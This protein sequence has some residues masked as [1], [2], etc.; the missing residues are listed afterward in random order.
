MKKILTLSLYGLFL[1]SSI[2]AISQPVT[3]KIG[4]YYT[5]ATNKAST[6][7]TISDADDRITKVQDVLDDISPGSY[8]AVLTS[9]TQIDY[10]EP[11]HRSGGDYT[12]GKFNGMRQIFAELIDQVAA[13]SYYDDLSGTESLGNLQSNEVD[14]DYAKLDLAVRSD[15]NIFIVDEEGTDDYYFVDNPLTEDRLGTEYTG[16]AYEGILPTVIKVDEYKTNIRSIALAVFGLLADPDNATVI[17]EESTSGS[18]LSFFSYYY[19]P[20][21]TSFILNTSLSSDNKCVFKQSLQKMKMD[22][23]DIIDVNGDVKGNNKRVKIDAGNYVRI[24]SASSTPVVLAPTGSADFVAITT[25]AYTTDSNKNPTC[26]INSN[27][28]TATASLADENESF[29]TKQPDEIISSPLTLYPNPFTNTF[30]VV[31]EQVEN[32]SGVVVARVYDLSGR[33]VLEQQYSVGNS[34]SVDLEMDGSSFS[35]GH[36]IIELNDGSGT[37]QR[38]KLIKE[39]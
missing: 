11:K 19:D 22:S 34:A 38:G 27:A 16:T 8:K 28:R 35:V 25:D 6:P 21:N 1:L 30:K 14:R 9:F 26:S 4:I 7:M 13:L 3:V 12:I 17:D 36:Y 37:P 5:S 39:R 2:S 18:L 32:T 31:Y 10:Q 29:S 24:V 20:Y 33:V 15:I 23:R